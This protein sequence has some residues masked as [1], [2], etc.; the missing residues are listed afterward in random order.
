MTWLV[1]KV[2]IHVN[3]L[4]LINSLLMFF[5]LNMSH[6]IYLMCSLIYIFFCD[7]HFTHYYLVLL[8]PICI[9]KSAHYRGFTRKQMLRCGKNYSNGE[10]LG[11]KKKKSK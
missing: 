4:E 6:G 7:L 3:K 5:E 1:Y 2:I 8:C 9:K 10:L 11:F